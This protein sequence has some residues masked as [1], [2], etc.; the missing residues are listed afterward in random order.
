MLSWSLGFLQ[1][2]GELNW[3]EP[4]LRKHEAGEAAWPF[5]LAW[6][7]VESAPNSCFWNGTQAKAI[8]GLWLLEVVGVLLHMF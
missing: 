2:F 8:L 4:Q 6:V 3:L 7:L 1:I 5:L